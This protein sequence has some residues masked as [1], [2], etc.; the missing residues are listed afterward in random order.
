MTA[1][2]HSYLEETVVWNRSIDPGYPFQAEFEGDRLAMRL[3]DFPEESLYTLM[4]K[5]LSVS[6]TGQGYGRNR[7]P[8]QFI[9]AS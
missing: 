6:M 8:K 9:A 2:V 7:R 1:N 4:V 5:R 3:N